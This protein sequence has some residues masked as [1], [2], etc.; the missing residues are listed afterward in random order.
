MAAQDAAY[1]DRIRVLEVAD[2][3]G[4]YCG[5]LLGGLGAD[6]VKI[7]PLNGESTRTYGPFLDGAQDVNRS[8]HFWH[9]NVGK[10]SATLDLDR[11]S[12]RDTFIAI[13][14]RCD[15]VVTSRLESYMNDRGIGYD[16]LSVRN[17]GLVYVNISP[18]GN[19]GPWAD[20]R[21]SDLIHLALGGVMMNCGYDPDPSGHYETPPLRPNAA[22]LPH[23]RRDGGN[24]AAHGALP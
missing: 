13:A 14:E 2:E 16:S 6:V 9:Y 21:G 1:L 17:S 22:G 11:D 7:E 4:E 15:V 20:Y 24:G 5:R 8:L 12:D 23:R 10:R 19:D 18:F 3:L